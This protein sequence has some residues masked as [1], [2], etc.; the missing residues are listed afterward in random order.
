MTISQ[1]LSDI[2]GYIEKFIRKGGVS[3]NR[4]TAMT[5]AAVFAC[6]AAISN[7]LAGLPVHV[8]RKK[9]N[10]VEKVTD[11]PASEKI[12][13]APN[14]E[15]RAF[16]WYRT[17]LMHALLTGN[18]FV[19]IERSIMSPVKALWLLDPENVT[20][21]RIDM[22]D[23][24]SPIVYEYRE[25]SGRNRIY[26]P[27]DI[28]HLKGI[29]WDGI[30]GQTVISN[31]AKTQIGI[32]L[33]M[34]Q[35]QK[36]FF[37]NGLNP[38]GIFEHPR[39]LSDKVKPTFLKAMKERF[40]GGGKKAKQ[41]M[42]LEDDMKFKPY[43]IK[44]CDQQFIELLK[45]NKV[46]ICGMFG[47]PQSRI[48]ISDS[49]TNYNNTE[50]EKYRYYEAGLLPWAIPDEQEMTYRLLTPE[51]RKKGL[52]I[53]YNFD[54]FLRGDSKTRAEV[55]R[56]WSTMGVPV[57][58]LLVYEDRNPV[59]GGDVG[60]VQVNMIPI[61]DVSGFQKEKNTPAA[62][63]MKEMRANDK[64]IS[65]ILKGRDKVRDRFTPLLSD[66]IEKIVNRESIALSKAIKKH[67][68]ARSEDDFM[69]W[70]ET[71]YADFPDYIKK[72]IRSIV[73]SYAST[74]QEVVGGEVGLTDV[75]YQTIE[76]EVAQYLDGYAR[77][78]LDASIGQIKTE[79][80]AGS[81]D[82][83]Q[84]RAD[85]W[86]EKRTEKETDETSVG[87][88]SMVAR[89]VILGAGYRLVWRT[90]RDSCPLCNQL[91]G[92][93]VKSDK[94]FTDSDETFTDGKGQPVNFRRTLY[95]PL[96]RGCD[97]VIVAG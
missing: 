66:G 27:E 77:Q 9:N 55:S 56:I 48:N 80:E 54:G 59:A 5:H 49:N 40:A 94:P 50:S 86:R 35:F 89:A 1:E 74:A 84:K 37:E 17:R 7:D 93:T 62:R 44:M 2:P 46:D 51:D 75:D 4:S 33:E 72:Q 32:G 63:S 30:D 79:Y 57:N 69:A 25:S 26:K 88:M 82:S 91:N 34:D 12:K 16:D 21:R 65:A 22:G 78:Y 53:K 96:H 42:I 11:H 90:R 6:V 61:G 95:S 76:N 29:S 71:F 92:R 24:R 73:V 68:G 14:R 38:G 23:D 39:T 67:Q 3:V 13:L 64:D 45:L 81:F 28:L 83:V 85:E 18:S 60:L 97:C 15:M 10:K 47:V 20:I 31:Y 52:Y 58:D 70:V 8:L 43:D 41:P 36:A 19:L 87:I